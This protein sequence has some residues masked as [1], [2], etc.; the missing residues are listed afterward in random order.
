MQM[1]YNMMNGNFLVVGGRE[2]RGTAQ[3]KILTAR[4]F[5]IRYDHRI[6]VVTLIIPI[7]AT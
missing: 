2:W 7:S 6:S 4:L 5:F 1:L 3:H